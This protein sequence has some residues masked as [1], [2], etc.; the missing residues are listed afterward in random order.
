MN[1]TLHLVYRLLKQLDV[2]KIHYSLFRIREDTIMIEAHVP[3]RYYEIEV[4]P[5]ERVEVEVYKSDGQ[6]GGQELIDELL[7]NYSEK[8]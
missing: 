6:I 3:G 8:P 4:F 5:D 7:A 1:S 2:A